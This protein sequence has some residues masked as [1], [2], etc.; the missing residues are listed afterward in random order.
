MVALKRVLYDHLGV[1][2]LLRPWPDWPEWQY[3]KLIEGRSFVQYI[4]TAQ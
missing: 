3:Y 4:I 2:I 1:Q